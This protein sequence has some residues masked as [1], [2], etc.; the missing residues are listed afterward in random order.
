MTNFSGV[1]VNSDDSF[2]FPLDGIMRVVKGFVGISS[3]RSS[4]EVGRC[5]IG[6]SYIRGSELDLLKSEGALKRPVLE[7]SASG[8]CR[9]LGKSCMVPGIHCGPTKRLSSTNGVFSSLM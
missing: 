6:S 8:C 2:C 4:S 9:C 3:D 7:A 5:S 1:G